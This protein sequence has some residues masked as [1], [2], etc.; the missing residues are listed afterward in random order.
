MV[1]GVGDED[2]TIWSHR[3]TLRTVKRIVLAVDRLQK[4]SVSIKDLQDQPT[5]NWNVSHR[6]ITCTRTISS[7]TSW[8]VERETKTVAG[9]SQVQAHLYA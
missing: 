6:F 2:V 5:R 3:Q 9:G 8:K 7:L 1:S 4:G